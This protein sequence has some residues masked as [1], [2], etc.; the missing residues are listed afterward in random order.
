M[1][2]LFSNHQCAGFFEQLHEDKQEARNALPLVF[3]G[4]VAQYAWERL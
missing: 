3:I 4:S 1:F 2:E